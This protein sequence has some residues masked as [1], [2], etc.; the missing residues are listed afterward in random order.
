MNITLC[1]MS[2][3]LKSSVNFAGIKKQ[4]AALGVWRLLF[5]PENGWLCVV[6][7]PQEVRLAFDAHDAWQALYQWDEWWRNHPGIPC[8]RELALLFFFPGVCFPGTL[9]SKHQHNTCQIILRHGLGALDSWHRFGRDYQF[10]GVPRMA[11][12]CFHQ[13][14]RNDSTT[15]QHEAVTCCHVFCWFFVQLCCVSIRENQFC[16]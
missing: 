4:Q 7:C 15:R 9:G 13:E 6:R 2:P 5:W 1:R 12:F 16:Q 10:Q 8:W 14:D 3:S 11:A